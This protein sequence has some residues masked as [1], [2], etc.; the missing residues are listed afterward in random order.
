MLIL[1]ILWVLVLLGMCQWM[2]PDPRYPKQFDQR[3]SY[4]CIWIGTVSLLV[5]CHY[6]LMAKGG[7]GELA[8]VLDVVAVML[9]AC[10][11]YGRAHFRGLL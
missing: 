2:T 10:L 3:F 11:H 5:Y 1:S 4:D 9:Y 6:A 7:Y 8:I